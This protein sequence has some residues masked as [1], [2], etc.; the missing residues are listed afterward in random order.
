MLCHLGKNI[1]AKS[2]KSVQIHADNSDNDFDEAKHVWALK[3]AWNNTVQ[4]LKFRHHKNKAA[5]LVG[6][7]IHEY[8]RL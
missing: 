6:A 5:S 8:V 3:R 2:G 7:S 1:I 4:L